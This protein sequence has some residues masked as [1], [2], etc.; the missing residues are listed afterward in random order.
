M[1]IWR[2]MSRMGRWFVIISFDNKFRIDGYII[3]AG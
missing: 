2:T 3:I 1:A